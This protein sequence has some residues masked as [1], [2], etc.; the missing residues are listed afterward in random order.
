M[1]KTS[2]ETVETKNYILDQLRERGCR[3]TKQREILIDVILREKCNNCKEIYYHAVKEDSEIGMATVYR[4]MNI[5]EDIGAL[6]W[7]NEYKL[8]EQAK[9]PN[10][11]FQ[12]EFSDASKMELRDEALR[13]VVEKGLDA[14]GHLKGRSVKRV[15]LREES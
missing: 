15:L 3:I 1:E 14:G 2:T 11:S 8:C 10:A 9:V 5:L 12:V 7:R 13:T 4:M 6:K